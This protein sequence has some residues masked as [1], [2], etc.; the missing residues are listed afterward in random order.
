[1]RLAYSIVR[2]QKENKAIKDVSQAALATIGG[3]SQLPSPER[4]PKA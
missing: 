1:M 2:Q 3:A 4:P